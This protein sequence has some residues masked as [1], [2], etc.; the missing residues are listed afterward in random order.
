[1]QAACLRETLIVVDICETMKL[2]IIR[3]YKR[4]QHAYEVETQVKG[5]W[6][7][8]KV[9]YDTL[10]EAWAYITKKVMIVANGEEK[11]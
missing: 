5:R 8:L 6:G 4:S 1:M 7:V 11:E 9:R 10:E 2:H 3:D